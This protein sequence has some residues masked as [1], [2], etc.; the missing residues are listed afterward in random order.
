MKQ[1]F[2]PPVDVMDV[3]TL[4][5]SFSLEGCDGAPS[6]PPLDKEAIFNP[7]ENIRQGVAV[8]DTNDIAALAQTV[9]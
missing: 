3:G 8:V 4:A 6:F 5:A 7:E 2:C 9:A 1:V